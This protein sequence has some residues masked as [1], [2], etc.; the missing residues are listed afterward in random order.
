M[1]LA[2][3]ALL[4]VVAA[5]NAAQQPHVGCTAGAD[6]EPCKLPSGDEGYFVCRIQEEY[7]S[8]RPSTCPMGEGHHMM[9][10]G[11]G[12]GMFMSRSSCIA[13]P[14]STQQGEPAGRYQGQYQRQ[15]GGGMMCSNNDGE[16]CEGRGPF[17]DGH[18]RQPR[19]ECGC[20]GGVCPT[21]LKCPCTCDLDSSS[22]TDGG[23]GFKVSFTRCDNTNVDLCVPPGYADTGR[24]T[25]IEDC[26]TVVDGLKP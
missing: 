4:A 22:S 19:L 15:Y 7:S 11:W 21:I 6:T 23:K 1:F 5:V 16:P 14:D 2:S 13:P 25:C 10:R 3:I 26:N 9:G 18:E 12:N 8:L 24:V 17:G 20:C